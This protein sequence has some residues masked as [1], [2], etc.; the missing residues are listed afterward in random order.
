MALF[1]RRQSATNVSSKCWF[2][3]IVVIAVEVEP[4]STSTTVADWS[5]TELQQLQLY[6]NKA[7]VKQ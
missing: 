2:V 3:G 1:C 5:P 7:L 6:G 4:D